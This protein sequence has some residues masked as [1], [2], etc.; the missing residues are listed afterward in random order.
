M[1]QNYL[2]AKKSGGVWVLDCDGAVDVKTGL[3]VAMSIMCDGAKF[4]DGNGLIDAI[5]DNIN[6]YTIDVDKK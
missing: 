1:P 3:M 2:V 5:A 6:L 4:R